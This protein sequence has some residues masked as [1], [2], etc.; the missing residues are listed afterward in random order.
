[1]NDLITNGGITRCA[2]ALNGS[3]RKTIH[4]KLTPSTSLPIA[5]LQ[6]DNQEHVTSGIILQP[7]ESNATFEFS[8]DGELWVFAIGKNVAAP[9]SLAGGELSFDLGDTKVNLEVVPTEFEVRDIK[10]DV[11]TKVPDEV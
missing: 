9:L 5:V 4:L 1:M 7:Q 2:I 8:Q 6:M 10:T 11:K 3:P